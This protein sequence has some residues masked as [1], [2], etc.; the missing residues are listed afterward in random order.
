[1][2]AVISILT[3]ADRIFEARATAGDTHFGAN[4]SGVENRSRYRLR[5]YLLLRVCVKGRR[6]RDHFERAG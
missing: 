6:R 1:M 4:N 5:Y 2:A 3:I